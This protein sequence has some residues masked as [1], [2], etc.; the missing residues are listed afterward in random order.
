MGS[1]AHGQLLLLART[2]GGMTLDADRDPVRLLLPLGALD[3]LDV[4]LGHVLVG[5]RVALQGN[6]D[7]AIL[8]S[9]PGVIR[10]EAKRTLESFG[11][12]EGH[13][14]NLG[15]GITPEVDPDH[16]GALLEAVQEFS[17]A[18]HAD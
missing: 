8:L 14:F 12:G 4:D 2:V 15:H 18:L 11:P 6:M 5:D 1:G 9:D 16:L 3:H 10:R 13:V 17:P 7:P